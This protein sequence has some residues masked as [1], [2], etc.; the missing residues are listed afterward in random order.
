VSISNQVPCPAHLHIM[1]FLER[2]LLKIH[3]PLRRRQGPRYSVTLETSL[4]DRFLCP[5]AFA[6]SLSLP[7][8]REP[9]SRDT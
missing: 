4:D 5:N 2:N 3:T 9:A 6:L 8:N 7:N 1:Y